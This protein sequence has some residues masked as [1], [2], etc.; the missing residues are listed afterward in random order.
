M[1]LEMLLMSVYFTEI[2]E[3]NTD[4]GTQLSDNT[5]KL[6]KTWSSFPEPW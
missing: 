5:S 2:K 6:K 1:P 4:K 3:I